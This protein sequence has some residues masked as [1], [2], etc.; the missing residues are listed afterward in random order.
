MTHK[1]LMI[2]YLLQKVALEDW[3]AV[4]DAA[5]DL[6]CIDVGGEDYVGSGTDQPA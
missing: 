2:A 3:H 1:E 6:K 4:W 5:I